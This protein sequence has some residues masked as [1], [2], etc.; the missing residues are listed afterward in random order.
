MFHRPP[1]NRGVSTRSLVA[2]CLV[3][4][5]SPVPA[6]ATPPDPEQRADG[7][8]G[9]F[10][11]SGSVAGEVEPG[12]AFG[13]AVALGDFNGDGFQDVAVG[14]PGEDIGSRNSAGAI[15]VLYGTHSGLTLFANRFFSQDTSGVPGISEAGDRFGASLA[16]GDFNHDFREDLAIG[17]PGEAIGSIA[18]AGA[19]NVLYGSGSGLTAASGQLLHQDTPGVGGAAESGDQFGVSLAAGLIREQDGQPFGYDDLFVGVPLENLGSTVDAGMVHHVRGSASG[20]NIASDVVLHENS[21]GVP[22]AALAHEEFGRSMTVRNFDGNPAINAS[23]DLAVSAPREAVDGGGGFDSPNAGVVFL[24]HGRTDAPG[25]SNDV[26]LVDGIDGLSDPTN[27]YFGQD[28]AWRGSLGWGDDDLV[29]GVRD[30]TQGYG[31]GAE[32][33]D[34]DGDPSA[35]PLDPVIGFD[36]SDG[37][38]TAVMG[39]SNGFPGSFESGIL[40][41]VPLATDGGAGASGLVAGWGAIFGQ[42]NGPGA[43]EANDVFGYDLALGDIDGE[44]N[45]DLVVGVPGEDVGSVAD[46]GG[47]VVAYGAN[48]PAPK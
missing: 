1:P 30:S 25:L 8:D 24:V 33:F 28:L 13:S 4:I 38:G 29:V 19:V 18:N 42:S 27:R 31:G 9:Y 26:D 45:D 21:A 32:V 7:T 47:I 10:N 12:D 5:A 44:E 2:L 20:L 41:G 3:G 35:E 40:V 16:V 15:N 23:G 11:Q 34:L 36:P 46:A 14:V 39:L 6:G 22:T 48:L 43:P 37:P 17:A